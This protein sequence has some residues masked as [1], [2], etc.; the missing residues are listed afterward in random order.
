MSK[1]GFS[2]L[3]LDEGWSKLLSGYSTVS[4]FKSESGTIFC[5]IVMYKYRSMEHQLN[6]KALTLHISGKVLHYWYIAFGDHAVVYSLSV[7]N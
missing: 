4:Y 2:D 7:T 1:A 5:L 3:G 6:R